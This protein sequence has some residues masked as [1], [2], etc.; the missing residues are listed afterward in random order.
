MSLSYGLGD[1]VCDC[2]LWEGSVREV[3]GEAL[4]DFWGVC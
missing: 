2:S 1:V 3:G 4:A